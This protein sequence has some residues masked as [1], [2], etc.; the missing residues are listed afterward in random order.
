M[1]EKEIIRQEATTSDMDDD[2]KET[3]G[4]R[5]LRELH[6][7]REEQREVNSRLYQEINNLRQDQRADRKYCRA[8][9]DTLNVL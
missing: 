2:I 5:I 7:F 4:W 6:Y 3:V 1:S 9:I 8:D